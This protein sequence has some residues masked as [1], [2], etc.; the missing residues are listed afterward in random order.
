MSSKGMWYVQ[1][2]LFLMVCHTCY[3]VSFVKLKYLHSPGVSQEQ[4]GNLPLLCASILFMLD[5]YCVF[6]LQHCFKL[7]LSFSSYTYGMLIKSLLPFYIHFQALQ[8]LQTNHSVFLGLPEFFS[9]ILCSNSWW[10]NETQVGTDCQYCQINTQL[11]LL[12]CSDD[13]LLLGFDITCKH[14]LAL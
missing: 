12:S 4:F 1:C 13:L 14:A 7:L 6:K 2:R 5:A 3:Y 11:I 9:L 8:K 10:Q